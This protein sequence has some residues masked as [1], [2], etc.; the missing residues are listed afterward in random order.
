MHKTHLEV[1]GEWKYLYR[2]FDSEGN[3]FDFMLSA[4]HDVRAAEPFFS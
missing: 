3:T 2:V 4:R 1:K